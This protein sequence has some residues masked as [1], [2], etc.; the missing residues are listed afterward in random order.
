MNKKELIKEAIYFKLY[1]QTK[2]VALIGMI[3][4]II[5]SLSVDIESYRLKHGKSDK[6]S[7]PMDRVEKLK[8]IR[9]QFSS[10]YTNYETLRLEERKV[11]RQN[12][13]LRLENEQLRKENEAF[14]KSFDDL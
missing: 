13:L 10:Y 1:D 4:D 14:K 9:D 6:L 7:E 5:V 8:E 11:F 3:D 12:K 2:A